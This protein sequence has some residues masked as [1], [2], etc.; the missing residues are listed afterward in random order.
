LAYKFDSPQA[1][2]VL[3]AIDVQV[4]R[5]GRITPVGR[6]EPVLVGNS[7][8][9]NVTLHN[10]AYIDMLELAIGDSVS[11][12]K[13]GDVIP[14]LEKVV[15][16]NELGNVTFRLPGHCPSC[17]TA[18]VMQGAH[19]FCPNKECPDQVR[20]A[21]EFFVGRSQMDIEGFGPQTVEL[22]INKGWLHSPSDIY[23]I[24][25]LE[26]VGEPGFGQKK[27]QGLQEAVQQSK[28]RPYR[29]VLLSLGLPD[30][31]KK[32]VDLLV[33]AGI[34]SID[35]LYR[36]VD[37]QDVARLTAIKGF[38]DVMAASLLRSLD[39]PSMRR[40]IELLKEA[41]LSFEQQPE[42]KEV[43]PQI[44]ANQVWVVTGSFKAFNPRSL[45]LKE[46][47][48]RGGSTRTSISKQTTHLL[49]GKGGGSKIEQARQVQAIIVSEEE[50]VAMLEEG[51]KT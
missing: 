22:L 33:D 25:Y 12:S 20:A 42:H 15:E 13:R 35:E 46:I 14:A 44:F 26:L 1:Q 37:E 6:V 17:A 18:L 36:I 4:G 9:S 40:L 24:N 45:A 31:G 27:A 2:S 7:V 21:I 47:E 41:G 51:E 16:K 43:L 32:A 3:S 38:G 10:Q 5:T 29:T 23:T 48:K 30:I 8:V 11:I 50:F 34:R 49:T 39:D 19:L 28:K